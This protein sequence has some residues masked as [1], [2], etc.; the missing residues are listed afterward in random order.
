MIL[1]IAIGAMVVYRGREVVFLEDCGPIPKGSRGLCLSYC[2]KS[3]VMRLWLSNTVMGVN[4][5]VIS[6]KHIKKLRAF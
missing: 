3:G 6:K 4:E 2:K 5:F 1:V